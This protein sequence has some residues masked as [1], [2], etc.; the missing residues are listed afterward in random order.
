MNNRQQEKSLLLDY[1]YRFKQGKIIPENFDWGN[2][3]DVFVKTTKEFKKLDEIND[4]E[5]RIKMNKNSL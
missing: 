3:L 2:L 1:M 5:E 4:L